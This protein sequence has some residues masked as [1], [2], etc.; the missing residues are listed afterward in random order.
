MALDADSWAPPVLGIFAALGNATAN[1]AWE[2]ARRE[3]GAAAA[4]L[5]P[6][7]AAMEER[8]ALIQ[9]KYAG[10]GFVAPALREAAAQ[11]GA[12]AAAAAGGDLRQVCT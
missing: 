8:L 6:K 10:R 1:A 7:A 3:A 5:V 11:P 9:T 2:G 4:P 12:L